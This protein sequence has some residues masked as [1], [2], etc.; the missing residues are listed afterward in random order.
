MKIYRKHLALAALLMGVFLASAS[1]A[2]ALIDLNLGGSASGSATSSESSSADASGTSSVDVRTTVDAHADADVSADANAQEDLDMTFTHDDAMED[3][4]SM[5]VMSASSVS[6]RADLESYARSSL[7]SDE[8]LEAVRFSNDTVE[9]KYKERGHFLALFPVSMNVTAKAHADGSVD[10]DYPWYAFMTVDNKDKVETSLKV[11]VD[12]ALRARM[13][14]SV[15][16]EGKAEH[17]RFTASESAMLASEIQAVL[18]AHLTENMEG[19]VGDG[20]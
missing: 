4:S 2:S 18:K 9:V 16:A 13:V 6:S 11:A 5:S 14:G 19:R 1:S 8:N 12:N 15:Q 20:E 3:E 7:K 17:P 10:L